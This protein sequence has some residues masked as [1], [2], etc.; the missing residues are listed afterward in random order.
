MTLCELNFVSF[1]REITKGSLDMSNEHFYK[2]IN[3]EPTRVLSSQTSLGLTLCS[4]LQLTPP[5]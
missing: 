5:E 4:V 2:L 1:S 3:N